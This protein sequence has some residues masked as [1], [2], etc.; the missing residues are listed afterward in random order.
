MLQIK[1]E[2]VMCKLLVPSILVPAA[3]IAHVFGVP[4]GVGKDPDII[5]LPGLLSVQLGAE[6]KFS[7]KMTVCAKTLLN[8]QKNN[9][10][11]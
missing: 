8:R 7:V 5:L 10:T 6:L 1:P 2:Q 9:T 3:L 4:P 11:V